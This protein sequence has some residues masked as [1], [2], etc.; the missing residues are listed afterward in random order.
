MKSFYR[1]AVFISTVI[2]FCSITATANPIDLLGVYPT[3]WWT[4][5]K[6]P[7]LQIMVHGENAGAYST[8]K[9][10]YPGIVINKVTKVENKNYLFVDITIS[11]T[12]KPGKFKFILSGGGI[13]AE[14]FFYELK[15]RSNQNGKTRVVGVHADDFV[16]LVLPDR[17]ANGDPSN[18]AFNDMRDQQ[19]DRANPFSRHGGDIQGI[20]K[21]L[22]YFEEL[23][24]TALWLNP[25]V[26]NDMARTQEGGASRST[27]H[28]YAFTDHYNVDKRYGG[29]EAY[30]ELAEA[31]HAKKIKIIQDAVYNHVGND[32]WFIR[33]M[34][35]KDWVNQWSTYTNTSY[36]DQ[37][38]VDPYAAAIDKKISVD[39]WFTPFLVD[40]NQRN[41]FVSTFLIQ[42]AI[43]TTEEFGIDAWRVDT[44]FY[45]EPAFLNKINDALLKEFPKLTVFGEAWVHT[46]VNSAFFS[47]NNF[48]N[49]G[50][51]HN[52]QGVTDFPLFFAMLDGLNQP[53]G[54]TEGVNR[55]YM[56]LAQ[57]IAYKD[58]TRNCIFLDNHDLDRYYSV[59]GE[60]F[61]KFKMGLNWL[62]TLRGIPQLYYGTEILMKNFK[63]P[64][65]AEVRKDFPG[66]WEGDAANKFTSSGRTAQ[67]NEAFNF[68]SKLAKFRKTSSAIG[69]GKLM[70]YVPQD[71]V[72]TY[73]RY[74]NNQTI[75]VISNTGTRDMKIDW[76]RFEERMKGFA[77][78]KDI[79]SGQTRDL[80]D[81]TIKPKESFVYELVK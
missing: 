27:Y 29:N 10:S 38:L 61:N 7:K 13:P 71:G 59:V 28:G 22:N 25:V 43:W 4:G 23:G 65:D 46:V 16:Y 57:D 35:M 20:T 11:A 66:G 69:K 72:Y 34:P 6:N 53:F 15:S 45:S 58:P 24:V 33:D 12:A 63:N 77:K 56:T 19:V 49:A 75:M 17:F 47:D 74:D 51:K 39:G 81:F 78:L 64:S 79:Q 3:H 42:H 67:E 26:E 2:L 73:F 76:T 5:M 55:V 18:D 60:D 31:A 37:P 68:I 21:H 8:C 54:W 14:D 36:K 44:Y 40:L 50:F 80:N 48:S 9:T 70:Q 62:M 30:K 32:H 1:N 41:P 52:V